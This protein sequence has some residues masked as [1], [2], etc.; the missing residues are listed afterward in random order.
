MST[1]ENLVK[2]LFNFYSDV[3][4]EQTVET[5]WAEIVD[6]DKGVFKLDSIPFYAPNLA[7][8]DTIIAVYNPDEQ[9]LTY[10][11][12]I[13]FSGNST[14]QIVILDNSFTANDIRDAFHA[15]GCDTEKFKE[16]YFVIDVPVALDYS[17]VKSKLE[18]LRETETIDYAEP[19]LSAE[20]RG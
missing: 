17:I 2:V 10:K 13:A 7:S 15:L 14:V 16:G 8:G 9:M 19:C 20:H 11:E 18:E 12:T 4:E 1:D 5:M 3:L 6:Q